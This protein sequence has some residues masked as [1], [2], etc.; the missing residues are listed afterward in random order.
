MFNP[1]PREFLALALT[2]PACI[3]QNP[4]FDVTE[5]GPTSLTEST[6]AA[7]STGATPTTSASTGGTTGTDGGTTGQA[8]TECWSRAPD[9]WDR[10]DELLDAGLG[11]EP[12]AGRISPDGL[13]LYYM[14]GDPKRP[15]RAKR[16]PNGMTF[17]SGVE[18]IAWPGV[19][20]GM[21][22]PNFLA[23]ETELILSG[24]DG[25][26][27]IVVATLSDQIWSDPAPMASPGIN[28]PVDDSLP[29]VTADGTR[30][31][32]Q[33]NDG[34]VHPYLKSPTW[35]L[36]EARRP[37]ASAPG[38][39]FGALTLVTLPGLSDDPNYP[40][41]NLCAS[42]APD[43]LRLFFASTYP[44]IL[45]PTNE[46]DAL[47]IYYTERPGLDQPWTSPVPVPTH[48]LASWETCP[49]SVTAD[50]C[51][52]IFHRFTIGIDPGDYR[53]FVATRSP[54]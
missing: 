6:S 32:F 24:R 43:G 26:D 5:A 19:T 49:S 12:S 51:T 40:H 27:K 17:D 7:G 38:T 28:T 13:L 46:R 44:K 4:E 10:V 52:L 34:P 48:S 22:Y 1:P 33:R 35:R 53:T 31:I 29:T 42:F 41:I 30:M 45:D 18:L 54:A 39:G 37:A 36:Y 8:P 50:G 20:I 11:F 2:L 3:R 47:S 9:D 23:D 15:Y 14:A 25:D 21:D 16:A